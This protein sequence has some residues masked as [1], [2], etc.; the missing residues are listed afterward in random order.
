MIELKKAHELDIVE[1]TEDLPEYG[2]R[3]GAQGTVVEVF[4]KPEEAY[5]IEFL[6]DSG[7]TSKIADWV[8]P[9]QIINVAPFVK[10]QKETV[11]ND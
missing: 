3:Q 8:K 10:E 5:M 2:L 6:E 1:L 4:D 11:P 9:D 7:A